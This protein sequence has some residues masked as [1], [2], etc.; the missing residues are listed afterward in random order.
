MDP[1]KDKARKVQATSRLKINGRVWQNPQ[2]KVLSCV[3]I[4]MAPNTLFTFSLVYS[5]IKELIYKHNCIQINQLC[6]LQKE[7]KEQKSSVKQGF[8][9]PNTDKLPSSEFRLHT[10]ARKMEYMLK[11][12]SDHLYNILFF[13]SCYK[14]NCIHNNILQSVTLISIS[15]AQNQLGMTNHNPVFITYIDHLKSARRDLARCFYSLLAKSPMSE[16]A[17]CIQLFTG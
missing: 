8:N 6:T 2:T 17:Q 4:S 14:L 5:L 13:A 9:V 11:N 3:L 15:S 12:V 1:N 16:L 10:S 7:E